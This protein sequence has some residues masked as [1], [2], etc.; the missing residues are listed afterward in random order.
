MRRWLAFLLLFAACGGD[1]DGGP[2]ATELNLEMP[3]LI[4]LPYVTAGGG[5]TSA[6]VAVTNVL[7]ADSVGLTWTVGGDPAITVSGAPER[8]AAG[9]TVMVTVAWAGSATPQITGGDLVVMNEH[10]SRTAEVWAVAGD[11]AL[12]A[13]GFEPVSPTGAGVAIDRIGLSAVVRMPSAPFPDGAAAWTDDRVHVFVPAD[14]RERDAHDVVLHFHGHNTTLD[15]TVAAHRYREQLYASGANAILVVP[16]GPVN[17]ASGDFGKLADPE[18]TQAFL[19]EILTVLYRAGRIQRPVLGDVILTSHSG[20]Y[21]AL[22]QNLAPATFHVAQIG[23]FDSVYGFVETFAAFAL[24][25]GR[26]RSNHTAAGG[27]DDNNRALAAMLEGMGLTV[28]DQPHQRAL[29]EV[30]PVIYATGGLHGEAT[31]DDAAYAEQ[32]R[33]GA[34]AGRRGPRVELRTATLAAGTVTV[35]WLA[36]RDPDVTGFSVQTSP[37]GTAWTQVVAAAADA[38]QAT[39]A[40]TGATRVRIVPIVESLAATARQPSDT[41]LVA[42]D[43]DVVIVDGFDRAADGSWSGLAHDF[44]ARVGLAAG[45]PVHTVSNEA[46]TE[47]GFE[48]GAYGTVIWLTGDDS[49]ADRSVDAAERAALDAYLAGGGHLVLSGSEIGYDLDAT[50]AGAAW[51][52]AATGAA[53]A[54]D[55]AGSNAAAGDGPLAAITSF[56]FGG[57]AAPYAEDFA[58]TFTAGTG[59]TVVLRYGGGAAAAVGISGRAVIVGFPLE[60]V[61]SPASLAALVPALIAFAGG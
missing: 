18:G 4:G 12:P 7:D 35:T 22:A 53:L 36:P 58:D 46:V 21:L 31:R 15:A 1:D 8:I 54:A 43:A 51:L 55:D 57:A 5:G 24:D 48:L 34:R 38:S 60:V 23:L 13:A 42:P 2:V 47:D 61:E 19:D 17:A 27:T 10:G 3:S 50:P 59:A 16:Q 6:A 33:W 37:N 52:A 9:E 45:A 20:G 26:L 56:P 30:A 32:L 41:Y 28:A 14:Y 29:R 39:F 25:G 11:P 49:T 40:Q 44:A